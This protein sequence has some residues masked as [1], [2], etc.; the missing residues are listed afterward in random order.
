MR[1]CVNRVTTSFPPI[2]LIGCLD[3]AEEVGWLDDFVQLQL[4]HWFSLKCVNS[5]GHFFLPQRILIQST[6]L[7]LVPFLSLV[8][9][10]SRLVQ[11]YQFLFGNIS[12]TNLDLDVGTPPVDLVQL[13]HLSHFLRNF[14]D[15]SLIASLSLIGVSL[16]FVDIKI[17]SRLSHLV[18]LTLVENK[19]THLNF[20]SA[21][22]KLR[23]LTIRHNNYDHT[24]NV[25][26]TT[27]LASLSE[28][29]SIDFQH[30]GLDSKNVS[31]L[32]ENFI[33]TTSL[34]SI[35]IS[36]NAITGSLPASL[37]CLV[38]LRSLDASFN[39]MEGAGESV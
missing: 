27:C 39:Q 8:P 10:K 22:T 5:V 31:E 37:F 4:F 16:K 13:P 20:V 9:H 26:N 14:N 6:E 35:N 19:I 28:L 1:W 15:L 30:N 24:S 36:N 3:S 17:W 12:R 25:W 2:K 38:S 32:A 23:H 34:R 18:Q 21:M 7:T 33:S 29:H 11:T